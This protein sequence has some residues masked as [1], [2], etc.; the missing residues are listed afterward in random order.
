[1][2]RIKRPAGA[3]LLVPLYGALPLQ[4]VLLLAWP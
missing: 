4:P 3:L 1:M 2:E